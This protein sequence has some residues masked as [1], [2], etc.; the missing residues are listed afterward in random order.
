MATL[1]RLFRR[2]A[3][4]NVLLLGMLAGAAGCASAGPYLLTGPVPHSPT[5]EWRA[6]LLERAGVMGYTGYQDGRAVLRMATL[7][8][9]APVDA[10]T[11]GW[12]LAVRERGCGFLHF[13]CK[14]YDVLIAVSP[15]GFGFGAE[16]RIQVI[17]YGIEKGFFGSHKVI[18]PAQAAR[19][20]ASQLLSLPQ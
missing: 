12:V 19:S 20:D 16:T 18:S 9:R 8:L 11:T 13:G 4:R 17:V 6:V 3:S 2:P 7:G 15:P 14:R 1:M 5:D 10:D